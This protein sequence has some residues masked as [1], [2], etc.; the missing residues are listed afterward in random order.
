ML[1][2]YI[3]YL[4]T[5]KNTMYEAKI[6]KK[7]E[8]EIIGLEYCIARHTHA[9]TTLHKNIDCNKHIFYPRKMDFC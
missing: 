6:N 4:I 3:M 2:N 8:R 7:R 5:K 1:Y 9:D